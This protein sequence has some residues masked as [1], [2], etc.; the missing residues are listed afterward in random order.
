MSSHRVDVVPVVLEPHPNADSLSIVRVFGWQ[1]VV[2]TA[3]WNG[4]TAGAYIQP[5]SVVPATPEYAFLGER[6]K[7][8][9]IRVR[10]F[11]GTISQG[12]LVAAPDGSSIGD[13]VAET[14]G[15]IHYEPPLQGTGTGGEAESAPPMIYAS[16]YDV[17]NLRRYCDL[18]IPGEPVVATEKIHGA[19][20]RFVWSASESRMY[21]GSRGEWKRPSG[22]NLW[23][24]ALE[25]HHGIEAFCRAHSDV[26]LYGE[27]FG[28][29]Q[30]LRY[31]AV[32]GNDIFFAAFDVYE[33]GNWWPHDSARDRTAP[34]GIRWVPE[35][36]RGEFNLAELLA[37]SDG[38]SL[39]PEANHPREG[40]VVKPLPDR[41]SE[42]IGRLQLKIVSDAYLEK[43]D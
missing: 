22:I 24:Q 8:R 34:Y 17:E 12:L 18:F 2:R 23:W 35:V 15:V 41:E 10:K 29:V 39:W 28:K 21:C 37:L 20:A 26:V 30:S 9:R 33:R 14:L 19:N 38:A 42:V 40:I 36:Y 32:P 6:E 43:G 5:D 13:D 25:R 27:V 31:G 4:V 3:D 7:D 16:K 1:V 11:R